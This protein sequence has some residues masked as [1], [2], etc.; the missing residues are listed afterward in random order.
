LVHHADEYT[1]FEPAT[2]TSRAIEALGIEW[3]IALL[4]EGI[5]LYA[6]LPTTGVEQGVLRT[7]QKGPQ[8][9]WTV[10][11][12]E[13]DGDR[14]STVLPEVARFHSYCVGSEL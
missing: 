10:K 9:A 6:G 2:S 3:P 8:R 14:F 13:S 1:I 11:L 5:V 7:V 12:G 4:D